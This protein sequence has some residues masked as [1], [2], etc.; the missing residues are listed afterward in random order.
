VRPAQER[1]ATFAAWCLGAGVQERLDFGD[2]SVD[3][4]D[5]RRSFRKQVVPETATPVHLDEQAA[6]VAQRILAR[7]QEGAALAPEEACVGAPWSD[8]VGV[9]AA[10]T[11]KRGHPGESNEGVLR[12]S[13]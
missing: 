2:A 1:C 11:K 12:R 10:P 13:F 9:G 6:Q 3:P 4:D 7:L 5:L 8:A